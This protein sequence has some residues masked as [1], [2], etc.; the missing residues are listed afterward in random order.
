ML[1]LNT[2]NLLF[3]RSFL[4]LKYKTK[5]AQA[6]KNLKEKYNSWKLDFLN[7]DKLVDIEKINN[8]VKEKKD[9]YKNVVVLGIGG[10]ALGTKAIMQA[11][12]W[13]YYNELSKEKRWN[14]PK[15]YI[16][17]NIDPIEI[18]ELL[19]LINLEKT[20]FIVISKSGSTIETISLF[21]FFKEKI[22]E[23]YNSCSLLKEKNIWKT[24]R[25]FLKNHFVIVAWENSN[26]KK[27][28]LKE[29]YEVFD[30][31][32][33]IWWRFSVFTPV[34]LLPLAFIWVD[35]NKILEWVKSFKQNLFMVLS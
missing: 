28:S 25:D 33:W 24:E 8:F 35:I 3:S 2:T 22:K 6:I 5:S 10:S 7:V 30:I 17:D 19:N 1:K 32:E 21:T 20:L 4:E 9:K 34:W 16:L 14:N 18:E 11:I 29:G 31:P 26:F 27:N 13:K 12:K 23:Y 15:L